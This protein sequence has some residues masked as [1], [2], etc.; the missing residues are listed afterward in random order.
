MIWNIDNI[1][2]IMYLYYILIFILHIKYDD[3]FRQGSKI[4]TIGDYEL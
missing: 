4:I 1:R 2:V 3:V